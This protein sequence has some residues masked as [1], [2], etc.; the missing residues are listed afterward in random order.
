VDGNDVL[1]MYRATRE[2]LDRANAGKG[3]T[4][5]EAVTYRLMMHT[6]ADDPNKYRAEDEVKL[7][8][9]RDPIA[10][11]R[12]YLEGKA[13][14]NETMQAALDEEIRNDIDAAV[15][16]FEARSGFRPDAPFDH[17]FGT[18]HRAIEEERAEFLAS[19]ERRKE[20]GHG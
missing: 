7:W 8:W 9:E 16:E 2:A 1:A 14:W 18:R 3:P 12:R 15:K 19:L 13:I 4:F 6:T 11:F 20:A 17:V 5:I 10:R